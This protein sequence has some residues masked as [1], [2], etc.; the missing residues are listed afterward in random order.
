MEN[1]LGKLKNS[2]LQEYESKAYYALVTY[3]NLTAKE[4]SMKAEIPHT[5]VYA[6]LNKLIEKGFCKRM[7]GNKKIYKA[8]QPVVAFSPVVNEIKDKQFN[9]TFQSMNW[10]FGYFGILNSVV[11]S[12]KSRK[13]EL[14]N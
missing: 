10:K 4:I 8:L 9:G 3:R 12:I 14:K 2:G 7:P 13:T 5:K 6:T 11:D 1:L